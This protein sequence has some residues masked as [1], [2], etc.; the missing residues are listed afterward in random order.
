MV[1]ELVG[2]VDSQIV[3]IVFGV[4]DCV[5]LERVLLRQ[6]VVQTTSQTPDIAIAAELLLAVNYELRC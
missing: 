4:V 2:F 5:T 6:Q 3:D 1:L